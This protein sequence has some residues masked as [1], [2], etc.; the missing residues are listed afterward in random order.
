MPP[1]DADSWPQSPEAAGTP[2]GPRRGRSRRRGRRC[3]GTARAR[4]T[5]RTAVRQAALHSVSLSPRP[6]RRVPCLV[7][8]AEEAIA[9]TDQRVRGRG[10]RPDRRRAGGA[11]LLAGARPTDG[12]LLEHSLT[13]AL[14]EIADREGPEDQARSDSPRVTPGV[15]DRPRPDGRRARPEGRAG[16]AE[17]ARRG[18]EGDRLW[19]VGRHPEWAGELAGSSATSSSDGEPASARRWSVSSPGSRDAGRSRSC[20][21][22]A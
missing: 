4:T 13:Y 3:S 10:P 12:P 21:P 16:G 9:R 22:S 5:T 1:S 7:D 19:I 17:V 2:S 20:L 14:I 18:A 11:G 8:A 6:R 15:P